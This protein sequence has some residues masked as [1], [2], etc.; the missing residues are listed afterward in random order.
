MAY[1][2]ELTNIMLPKTFLL[3]AATAAHQVE[4]NNIHSDYWRMEHLPHTSFNEPSGEAVGHYECFEE[5]IRLLKKAGLNA[6][7]FSIEWARIEPQM[8]KYDLDALS[9]YR[10]VISFCRSEGVEPLVTLHHF[11]SP[12]WLIE[13]G[14]W[15]K[16]ETV[17]HFARYCGFIAQNLGK[18]LTWVCTINE[19]NMGQQLTTII[20]RYMRSAQG[21]QVG[22]NLAR[23]DAAKALALETAEA[24]HLKEGETAH[25]FLSQRTPQEEQLVLRAHQAARKALKAENPHL[26]VGLSLSLHDIQSI[27]GGEQ[28]AAEEWKREFL[29][30]LP[31]IKD[32]EFMGVQNYT[33][34]VYGPEGVLPVPAGAETTLMGYEYYPQALA[35][36][37]RRAARSYKGDILVTENG[38]ATKDD[39][40]RVAFIQEAL[41]GVREC[42]KEG[43]PVKGYM[44]W[45]LLDNFEWQKGFGMTFGLIAVDRQTMQRHPKPSLQYLGSQIMI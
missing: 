21:L 36:V 10:D 11:T 1:S 30:Y 44:H 16:E 2:K 35:Q 12:A 25:T 29:F 32:D 27:P 14:G 26:K 4:G 8:G 22:M 18:E 17:D 3:G 40:R 24:F 38:I 37:I 13:Q 31:T 41:S 20:K 45:S 42:I 9:H 39:T 15:G 43:I 28:N 7:R 33:R 34:D 5:D 6:Y 19:A 23:A